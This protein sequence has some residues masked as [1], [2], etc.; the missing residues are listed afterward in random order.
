MKTSTNVCGLR[1]MPHSC[2][3]EV[4]LSC[5]LLKKKV[6]NLRTLHPGIDFPGVG[7]TP[8]QSLHPPA[9]EIH[10]QIHFLESVTETVYF[11]D[12]KRYLKGYQL[13]ASAARREPGLHKYGG[14]I[15][16]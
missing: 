4:Q 6:E 2:Q 16:Q 10:T 1:S 13:R 3:K 12:C 8:R 11:S 5:H 9:H 15:G 14:T 7:L